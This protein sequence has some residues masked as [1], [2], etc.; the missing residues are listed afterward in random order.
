MGKG[1][2]FG[3]QDN[4]ESSYGTTM[5]KVS[6]VM[7]VGG[8]MDEALNETMRQNAYGALPAGLI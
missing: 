1:L 5:D 6:G 7:L 3:V 2:I 4:G 8:Y